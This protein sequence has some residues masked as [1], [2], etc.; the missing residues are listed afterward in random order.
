MNT[1]KI[2]FVS[3]A[4]AITLGS[5][6][7]V[8]QAQ[9]NSEEGQARQKAVRVQSIRQRLIKDFEAL[10][11]FV[12][13]ENHAEATAI[14]NE[15]AAD[16]DLNNIE[17]AYV[18]NFRGNICFSTDDLDCAIREFK[19][20]LITPDGIPPAFYNQMYYVVAQVYFSQEDYRNA[21]DYAQ[22]WFTTQEAPPADAYM[23]VGQAQYMLQ[24]FDAALPNVIKGI[25]MYEELGSIPKEGWLNLLSGIYRQKDDYRNMLPVLKKLAIHYP[26]KTYL[27]AMAGIY[28]ELEDQPKMSAL[29]LAM[30]DYGLITS[31]SEIVTLASLLL[32]QESAFKASEVLG[33]GF[34]DGVLEKNL[35]NYQL[36]S[37]SL[38]IAKEHEKAIA[39]MG[40]A[41]KLAEDG[42]LYIQLGQSLMALNRWS[43][44]ETALDQGIKKG[45]LT[46]TG[47]A[48][49]SLGSVQ[50]EQQKY[51]TAKA[52]FNRALRYDDMA[53]DA[54]N[55]VKYIDN[56]VYRIKELEKPIVISTDVEV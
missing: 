35:R 56:E 8:T 49:M 42:K 10:A 21:L 13:L 5:F 19:K 27:Q 3:V 50:F 7:T 48:V 32:G 36:Y 37:Q 9:N 6:G 43:E 17:K 26:K 33:K 39:P 44:A 16:P 14:L 23:L 22:Q 1:N 4:L 24:N 20:I 18:A 45:K 30:Y 15:L 31:E 11:E 12:E 29:Y 47:R 55:W 54:A 41:A 53:T 38:Y 46:N 28:N 25:Q 34:D 51:E 2:M 52:T 40:Q